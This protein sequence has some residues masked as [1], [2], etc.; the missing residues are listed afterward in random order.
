V[1]RKNIAIK[2]E[3]MISSRN[4]EASLVLAT[5]LNFDCTLQTSSAKLSAV[6]IS[7]FGGPKLFAKFCV[8]G[9]VLKGLLEKKFE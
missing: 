6:K 1:I 2:N 4:A 7:S 5:Y 3:I 9:L 8:S